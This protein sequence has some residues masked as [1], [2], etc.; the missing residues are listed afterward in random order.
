M[1]PNNDYNVLNLL[2][3]NK[4]VQLVD[5]NTTVVD[6]DE[7][8]LSKSAITFI[9][10]DANIVTISYSN[11]I[12]SCRRICDRLIKFNLNLEPIRIPADVLIDDSKKISIKIRPTLVIFGD[13]NV[14][15]PVFMLV[16]NILK[17]PFYF[18]SDRATLSKNI[19]QFKS[20]SLLTNILITHRYRSQELQQILHSI[21]DYIV[22]DNIIDDF[23]V[24]LNKLSFDNHDD[25]NSKEF[26]ILNISYLINT[27]GTTNQCQLTNDTTTNLIV[28]NKT[29]FVPHASIQ[30]NVLD[31]C[32]EFKL[33]SDDVVLICSPFSFDPSICDI[34]VA[35]SSFCHIIITD[36]CV[37]NVWE[38]F[39]KIIFQF[40]VNYMTITPSLWYRIQYYLFKNFQDTSSIRLR[41]VNFGGEIC[42]NRSH[43]KMFQNYPIEFRNLYGLSEMSAW[44]SMFKIDDDSLSSSCM[45]IPIIGRPLLNTDVYMNESNEIILESI[46]RKCLIFETEKGWSMYSKL[47]TNDYGQSI[48][49][50]HNF[51][52]DR[53]KSSNNNFIK[54]NGI[55]CHLRTIEQ[56]LLLEFGQ[57]N[58]DSHDFFIQ[59]CH[60]KQGEWKGNLQFI[61]VII[62]ICPTKIDDDHC[63]QNI[64]N[65]R[66]KI[67]LFI[68]K[69]YSKIPF[70]IHLIDS[71]KIVCLNQNYKLDNSKLRQNLDP[72][73]LPNCSNDLITNEIQ[74]IISNVLKMEIKT[75]KPLNVYG[76][77]SMMAIEIA[78]KIEDL[79]SFYNENI[80][81][82][83]F[84][85][86]IDQI[87]DNI[88]GTLETTTCKMSK[89]RQKSN[90]YSVD[91]IDKSSK[92]IVHIPI[93]YSSFR[94][95]HLWSYFM[96][97]CV[98]SSPLVFPFNSNVC[99]IK[100]FLCNLKSINH[101]FLF[102]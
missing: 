57:S 13:C 37:K 34:F 90:K 97:Q 46:V 69:N 43:L 17:L 63:K 16:A 25:D 70:R 95:E 60:T 99:N 88:V 94:I 91:C 19:E 65:I 58:N 85:H 74:S 36:N 26:Q 78:T 84:I 100:I 71:T 40:N 49:N 66:Q 11:L 3:N 87:V 45:D 4:F 77:D 12:D 41:Y 48:D 29:I 81:T 5:S 75:D 15:T 21:D 55:K 2:L 98:D 76:I 14:W 68:R 50:N 79:F 96:E 86:T 33:N 7:N 27:S 73:Q 8:L 62:T 56:S 54:L 102:E 20:I 47:M 42:P 72:T 51:Y 10:L 32:D 61:D 30:R 39:A 92:T 93:C 18:V 101:I 22:I 52:F 6:V 38:N 89:K 83:L 28:S 80:Y 24:Y 82:S 1:D 31:F 67:G 23:V 44:A 35:L 9:D 59:N 53:R 64:D